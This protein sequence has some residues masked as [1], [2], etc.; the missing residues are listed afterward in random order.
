MYC[1]KWDLSRVYV[2]SL[3]EKIIYLQKN[4]AHVE[5]FTINCE[6]LNE[7]IVIKILIES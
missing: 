6:N 3:N 2:Y 7:I 1:Q 4:Y 5:V